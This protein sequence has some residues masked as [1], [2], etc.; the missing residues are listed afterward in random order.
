MRFSLDEWTGLDDEQ[1]PRSDA[2]APT[3]PAPAPAP[4]LSEAAEQ[5]LFSAYADAAARAVAALEEEERRE[6]ERAARAFEAEMAR[7]EEELAEEEQAE[8]AH[9]EEDEDG[10]LKERGEQTAEDAQAAANAKTSAAVVGL[11]TSGPQRPFSS[12]SSVPSGGNA[13]VGDKDLEK[14]LRR[15]RRS[16]LQK[17]SPRMMQMIYK[18]ALIAELGA[19]PAGWGAAIAEVGRSRLSHGTGSMDSLARR[20]SVDVNGLL[21][22]GAK[23][24]WGALGKVLS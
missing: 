13:A 19:L 20:D 21:K 17:M 24:R 16:D 14:L 6:R 9:G 7:L 1:V 8:L 5:P 12:S 4:V 23:A 10:Q 3:A 15:R 18:D 2:P 22:E 11:F